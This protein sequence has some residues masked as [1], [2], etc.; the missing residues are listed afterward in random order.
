[1]I[2]SILLFLILAYVYIN[3]K[4]EDKLA[5]NDWKQNINLVSIIELVMLMLIW[6]VID[7]IIPNYSFVI[8]CTIAFLFGLKSYMYRRR[9]RLN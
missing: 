6:R 8:M 7:E 9:N 5:W 1:M 3:Y 2:Y 4:Y